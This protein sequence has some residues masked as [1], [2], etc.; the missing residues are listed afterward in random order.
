MK[1]QSR[2]FILILLVWLIIFFYLDFSRIYAKARNNPVNIEF[3]DSTSL[4]VQDL[5][6]IAS[7][8][9]QKNDKVLFIS[10]DNF[11]YMY[12]NL[13]SYPIIAKWN[14]TLD[15][16]DLNDYEFI[17]FYDKNS[18]YPYKNGVYNIHDIN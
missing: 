7:K 2:F 17:V 4:S 9:I 6:S 1:L 11:S 14:N 15:N 13:L 5:S 12:F 16:V 10:E 18:Y 3:S 8:R